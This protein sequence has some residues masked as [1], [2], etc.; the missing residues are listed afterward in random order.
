[1]TKRSICG[2][3]LVGWTAF[4]CALSLGPVSGPTVF[5]RPLEL[6]APIQFDD[7]A[8]SGGSGCVSAEVFYGDQRVDARLVQVDVT[9][10]AA[11]QL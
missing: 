11:R 7:V 10:D 2:A 4:A 9:P 8:Q 1:M 3:V 5:G 6:T